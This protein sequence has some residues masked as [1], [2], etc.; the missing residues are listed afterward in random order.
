MR[1]Q[2][3]E[4]YAIHPRLHPPARRGFLEPFELGHEVRKDPGR[5]PTQDNLTDRRDRRL[6]G[7]HLDDEPAP[8]GAKPR[9]LCRWDQAVLVSAAPRARRVDCAAARRAIGTRNGEQLT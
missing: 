6:L 2:E 7:I 8:R 5:R 9:G 1:R 4:R 3:I